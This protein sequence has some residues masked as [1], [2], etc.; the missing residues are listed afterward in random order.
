MSGLAVASASTID[1][2]GP[3][4]RPVSI[5]SATQAL[6]RHHPGAAGADDLGDLGDAG[7]AE[8]GGGDGDGA[9]ERGRPSS[10][11]AVRAANRLAASIPPSG[12]GGVST[13]ISGT[14]ATTAG[15]VVIIITE[16]KAP[17]PRGT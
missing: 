16:G 6:G 15:T 14:P 3:A 9:A 13:T 4:G 1:S 7:G 12:V 10:T 11:P 17:L 2:L 8:G 5:R